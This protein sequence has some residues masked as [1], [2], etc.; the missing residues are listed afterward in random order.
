[1]TSERALR[2]FLIIWGGQALSLLGSHLVQFALIW[3]LTETTGSATVLAL[4]SLVGLLPQVVLGPFVGVLVDRWDRRRIMLVADAVVAL[5]TLFLG[6]LFWSGR[7]E[8]WHV[9]PI[10]FIRALG[11]GFHWPAM[12][13]TASLMVPEA[14]LTRVQGLNQTLNGGLTVIG[15]PLGALLLAVLPLQGILAIDVVTA[16]VAI[17]PLLFIRVPSPARRETTTALSFWAS[18]GEELLDGLRYVRAWRG[19]LLLMLMAGL[20]NLLLHPAFALLPILVT[21]HFRGEAIHL[22]GLQAAIGL[23]IVAGGLLLGAWGGFR[24]RIVTTLVG[25]SSLGLALI[26]TSLTPAHLFGAAS[27]TLFLA[28]LAIA[29]TDGPLMAIIQ[30]AVAPEMQGRVFTLLGSVAKVM[31]PLGLLIAGPAA[32]LVGVRSWYLVTGIL[33]LAV[34]A[35]GF[36]VPTLL[37]IE[38]ERGQAP[39]SV[40]AGVAEGVGA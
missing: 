35:S 33:T 5:A 3:W 23:G 4:A 22:G 30:A 20:I 9:F 14:H 21:D 32:D 10:L 28:G 24:R 37:R 17:V 7:A 26:L 12:Q 27:A 1:M 39:A 2:P 16:L 13:A 31:A 25:V 38:E 8:V 40:A 15:A 18:F 19:L 6:Y 11:G 34:G 29:L 36:L